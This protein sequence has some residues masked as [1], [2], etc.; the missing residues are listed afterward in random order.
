MYNSTPM[1]WLVPKLKALHN[2]LQSLFSS[3]Y[4]LN[5][6]SFPFSVSSQDAEGCQSSNMTHLRHRPGGLGHLSSSGIGGTWNNL[7]LLTPK[8]QQ[9]LHET[10]TLLEL[11]IKTT[12]WQHGDGDLSNSYFS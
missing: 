9:L 10:M 2:L 6:P 1:Y 3:Y 4:S 5:I 11:L 8:Q 7:G 12:A